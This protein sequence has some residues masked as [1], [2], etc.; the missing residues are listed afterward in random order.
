MIQKLISTNKYDIKCP[1]SMSPIGICIHNT[2]NDAS[3]KNEISY[4]QSNN[5]EVSFHIAV[6]DFE[7]I[8]G[9][10]FDRNGWHAGDGENGNGNRN[11]IA[12]EICYSKGGGD[13]FIKAEKR[14]AKV[15]A[16]LLKQFGW[17]INNVKKHQDFSEKYCPHRTLD[18]GWERFLNMIQSELNEGAAVIEEPTVIP[19]ELYR[20]RKSWE[21]VVSQ[22]GAY[23]ILNNAID[24]CNK[25]VGHA[26]YDSKGNKVYPI[27]NSTDKELNRYTEFGKCTITVN[28]IDFRSKPYVGSDNPVEGKYFK[29]ESVNY[30]LVVITEF[31]TWISWVGGTGLRKIYAYNR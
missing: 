14:A 5:N 8:Q 16:Q 9:I 7:E 17:G 27:E 3:A 12:I 18:M 21:D 2:A 15:T 4:M 13:R 26:V 30:D 6:D 11:H 22:K 24:E 19:N 29:N 1:Y 20:V 25:N 23:S 31:Y 10:P 28:E